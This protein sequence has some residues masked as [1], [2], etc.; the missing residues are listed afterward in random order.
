MEERKP[1]GLILWKRSVAVVHH[2]WVLQRPSMTAVI[3][4][5]SGSDD[6]IVSQLVLS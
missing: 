4:G 6:K 5:N 1:V 3:V 2:V